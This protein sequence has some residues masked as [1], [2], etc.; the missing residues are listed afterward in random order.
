MTVIPPSP[1]RPISPDLSTPFYR[2]L[3]SESILEEEEPL[4]RE[5]AAV[6]EKFLKEMEEYHRQQFMEQ[7]R[8]KMFAHVFKYEVK[9]KK[10]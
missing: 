2:F 5:E 8:R 7:A 1:P 9:I 3:K 4:S 10:R 6:G